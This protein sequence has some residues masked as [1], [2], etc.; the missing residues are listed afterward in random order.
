M[1]NEWKAHRQKLKDRAQEYKDAPETLS[2]KC[3][4][5]AEA[6]QNSNYLIVYT[7]AG[8]STAACIPDYRGSNGIWTLLQQGKDIGLHDLSRAE[9]TLTHMALY[10]LYR[11]GILKHVVSQN[12]DGLHLRSGVPRSILSEVHGNMYL[13]VCLKC[14]PCNHYLRLFDVTENTARY[15]HETLRLCYKLSRIILSLN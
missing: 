14:K 5:L 12:C 13:E 4:I 11:S 3:K 7:G 9:P 2:E 8:I 10:C 15:S 6:V 1:L